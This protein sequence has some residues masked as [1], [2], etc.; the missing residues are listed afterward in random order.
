MKLKTVVFAAALLSLPALAQDV[1]QAEVKSI[2][3]AHPAYAVWLSD[4]KLA[5]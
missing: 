5:H 2:I 1:D 3:A 4:P